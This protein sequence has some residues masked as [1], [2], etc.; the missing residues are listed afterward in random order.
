L[1]FEGGRESTPC[2]SGGK[3]TQGEA[4]EE[5]MKISIPPKGGGDFINIASDPKLVPDHPHTPFVPLPPPHFLRWSPPVEGGSKGSPPYSPAIPLNNDSR[6][7]EI[8]D[9]EQSY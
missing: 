2:R 8:P 9:A 5:R 7:E 6:H 3:N 1:P 4:E